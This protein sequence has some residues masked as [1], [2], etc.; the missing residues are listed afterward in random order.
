M[1]MPPCLPTEPHTHWSESFGSESIG[2]KLI[3]PVSTGSNVPTSSVP[4]PFSRDQVT[5]WIRALYS[6]PPWPPI[7]GGGGAGYER[8]C[9]CSVAVL[10]GNR[11]K[12]TPL[13]W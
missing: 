10:T 1:C 7:R 8:T 3:R 11:R 9:P 5:I 4:A 12:A 13:Q 6:V 2:S